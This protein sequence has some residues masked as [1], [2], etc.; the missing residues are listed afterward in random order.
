VHSLLRHRKP[1][2]DG[3]RDRHDL[4]LEVRA[5][6]RICLKH[7]DE[8]G[9]RFRGKGCVVLRIA[10]YRQ[11]AKANPCAAWRTAEDTTQ[12]A[13]QYRD[14]RLRRRLS[15]DRDDLD[16][17]DGHVRVIEGT[18]SDC[19]DA[20]FAAKPP[21]AVVCPCRATIRRRAAAGTR[22]TFTSNDI[23]LSFPGV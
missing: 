3:L 1:C 11:G 16:I 20:T 21:P 14:R 22:K 6:R 19:V 15:C 2:R 8:Y 4:S 13:G 7:R 23:A 18:R 12:G 10:A 5:L 17:N 9:E